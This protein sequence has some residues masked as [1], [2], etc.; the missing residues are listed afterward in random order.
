MKAARPAGRRRLMTRRPAR[1]RIGGPRHRPARAGRYAA[2]TARCEHGLPDRIE[3]GGPLPCPDREGALGPHNRAPRSDRTLPPGRTGI[4][5]YQASRAWPILFTVAA[6]RVSLIIKVEW[7]EDFLPLPIAG[8]PLA[9]DVIS[10]PA[11]VAAHQSGVNGQSFTRLLPKVQLDPCRRDGRPLRTTK[12]LGVTPPSRPS[13]LSARLHGGSL[14]ASHSAARLD[15]TETPLT[16][17]RSIGLVSWFLDTAPWAPSSHLD[18]PVIDLT[19]PSDR[20][21]PTDPVNPEQGTAQTVYTPRRG[22]G[23]RRRPIPRAAGRQAHGDDAR[24]GG[25][26]HRGVEQ[27]P[28][29]SPGFT[30]SLRFRTTGT[31]GGIGRLGAH[32]APKPPGT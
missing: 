26:D 8:Q 9:Q 11:R 12:R 30:E 20:R 6:S 1:C 14:H 18:A 25:N 7:R 24:P 15:D 4:R 29:F 31:T 2:I 21:S 32:Q 27:R 13:G 28:R 3:A 19:A 10:D 16:P 23:P 5:A 17:G 22:T